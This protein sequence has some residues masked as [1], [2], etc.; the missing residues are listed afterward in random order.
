M[1]ISRLTIILFREGINEIL[2]GIGITPMALL[3]QFK[4]R[5]LISVVE[6]KMENRFVI[7]FIVFF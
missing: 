3:V 4:G 7:T 1:F 2:V 5:L 6:P